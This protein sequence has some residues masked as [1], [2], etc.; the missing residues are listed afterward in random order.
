[1]NDPQGVVLE[2]QVTVAVLVVVRIAVIV[3]VEVVV[4]VSVVVTVSVVVVCPTPT[5]MLAEM[6]RAAMMIAEATTSRPLEIWPFGRWMPRSLDP[7]NL[8]LIERAAMRTGTSARATESTSQNPTSSYR[9]T[10]LV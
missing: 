8:W 6:S 7:R 9:M 5:N 10:R 3:E 4:R 1:V 2:E